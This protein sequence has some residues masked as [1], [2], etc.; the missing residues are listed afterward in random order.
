MPLVITQ[1]FF[2]YVPLYFPPCFTPHYIAAQDYST[3]IQ[4]LEFEPGITE[5][6]VTINIIDDKLIEV[7]ETFVLHLSSGAGTFLSPFAQA[8]VTIISN[9]GR[10][11]YETTVEKLA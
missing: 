8:E 4:I 7:D 3:V 9:D 11:L 5:K 10:D 2:P 6:N 1:I